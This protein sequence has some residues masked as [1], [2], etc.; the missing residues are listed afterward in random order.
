MSK[1]NNFFSAILTI[2]VSILLFSCGSDVLFISESGPQSISGE[3][4]ATVE[5][6]DTSASDGNGM[7]YFTITNTGDA[8]L[9]NVTFNL[10]YRVDITP[11][12]LNDDEY[13]HYTKTISYSQKIAPG[14]TR[15]SQDSVTLNEIDNDAMS[16]ESATFSLGALTSPTTR[17]VIIPVT[18]N[19]VSDREIGE[20]RVEIL[21]TGTLHEVFCYT[22]EQGQS[23]I[24][25]SKEHGTVQYKT[26]L[27]LYEI[28]SLGSKTDNLFNIDTAS[29]IP[30][31]PPSSPY[32]A[33]LNQNGR[34]RLYSVSV[35][36]VEVVD[37]TIIKPEQIYELLD[38]E[39]V[40]VDPK[41]ITVQK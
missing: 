39:N 11:L 36:K 16:S 40:T 34:H 1:Q 27:S 4:S 3:A 5:V 25:E 18:V 41:S 37:K 15:Y 19:N 35:S 9:N 21:V 8:Y 38:K 12:D 28:P 10:K 7:V 14:D 26:G 30:E 32:P 24:V 23:I 2:V 13:K 31:I 29:M 6:E 17:R 20:I 33:D 22:N